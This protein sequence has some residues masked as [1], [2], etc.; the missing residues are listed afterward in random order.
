[1]WPSRG[2]ATPSHGAH[3]PPPRPR[4]LEGG[5]R[6]ARSDSAKRQKQGLEWRDRNRETSA[7]NLDGKIPPIPQISVESPHPSCPPSTVHP[8]PD[9]QS[10]P[11]PPP[12]TSRELP[13]LKASLALIQGH[14]WDRA[15]CRSRHALPAPTEIS[16]SEQSANQFHPLWWNNAE[17][18]P[19][20]RGDHTC[21]F[22]RN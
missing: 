9:R 7:S 17:T 6:R 22:S 2:T 13:S 11:A 20:W 5:R 14:P 18:W 16:R 4:G 19:Q 12:L 3:V 21:L 10:P 1:M 8:T 15:E